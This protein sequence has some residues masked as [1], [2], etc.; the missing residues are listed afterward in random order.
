M[1]E[2]FMQFSQLKQRPCGAPY[3]EFEFTLPAMLTSW[4]GTSS[5]SP[6]EDIKLG[7]AGGFYVP[8]ITDPFSMTVYPDEEVSISVGDYTGLPDDMAQPL[9]YTSRGGKSDT[10]IVRVYRG[11]EAGAGFDG[12]TCDFYGLAAQ[13]DGVNP[14]TISV[15]QRNPGQDWITLVAT[16]DEPPFTTSKLGVPC[17]LKQMLF[18]NHAWGTP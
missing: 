17:V 16:G 14:L 3:A 6:F 5:T 2:R 13:W 9:F 4:P 15:R 11:F 18:M 7:G 12:L 10:F 8:D 1:A